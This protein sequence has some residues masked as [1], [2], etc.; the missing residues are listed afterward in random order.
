M[1]SV[2]PLMYRELAGWFHLLTPPGDYRD[3]AMA[4]L[5]LLADA[6]FEARRV[7]GAEGLD[8]FMGTH[9]SG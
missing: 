6:G 9:P 1:G 5:R 3:E 7:V 4:V 8:I 2:R